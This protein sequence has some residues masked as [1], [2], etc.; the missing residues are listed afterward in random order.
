MLDGTEFQLWQGTTYLDSQYLSGGTCEFTGLVPGEYTIKEIAGNTTTNF[1]IDTDK[2]VT[3]VLK[4]QENIDEGLC[5][6]TVNFTNTFKTGDFAFVKHDT[7]DYETVLGGAVYQ[8][9]GMNWNG[10]A[11]VL[12]TYT[13]TTNSSGFASVTNLTPGVYTFKEITAPSGY[14]IDPTTYSITIF[15]GRTTEGEDVYHVSD[16]K[17]ELGSIVLAKFEEGNT[18]V[19]LRGV[20]FS[21]YKDSV[22]TANFVSQKSTDVNG[23]IVWS[24]LEPGNYVVVEDSTIAGYQI[25]T[26]SKNVTLSPGEYKVV[27]LYNRRIPTPTPTPPT[28]PPESTPTPT[29]TPTP[30]PTPTPTPVNTDVIEIDD[31]DPAFGP[32]TGEGDTLFI[33]IGILLLLASGLFLLRKKLILNK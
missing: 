33:A 16:E 4:T 19:R 9:T 12:K 24:S 20:K 1:N 25:I 11:Y 22:S 28:N 21:L 3:L 31:V 15:V 7:D 17:Y 23:N 10:S 14:Q 6:P 27:L 5:D 32:E 8:L 30:V 26:T 2:Q 13:L 29:P 18:S